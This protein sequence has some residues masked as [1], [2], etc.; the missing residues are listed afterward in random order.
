MDRR[1]GLI[2]I[3]ETLAKIRK[4]EDTEVAIELLGELEYTVGLLTEDLVEKAKIEKAEQAEL[5][6]ETEE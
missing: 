3:E 2:L 1:E 5:E 6:Q 4:M